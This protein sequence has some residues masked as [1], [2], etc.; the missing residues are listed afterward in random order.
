MESCESVS[1]QNKIYLQLTTKQKS[2]RTNIFLPTTTSLMSSSKPYLC[3][4]SLSNV[5]SVFLYFIFLTG[6]RNRSQG[7]TYLSVIDK[8]KRRTSGDTEERQSF[9]QKNRKRKKERKEQM[10]FEPFHTLMSIQI[11]CLSREWICIAFL[12]VFV[13]KLF[14]SICIIYLS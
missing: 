7:R 14:N 1:R 8:P 6:Y 11:F 2:Q 10:G 3:K 13:Y 12:L 4:P 5:G 9:T